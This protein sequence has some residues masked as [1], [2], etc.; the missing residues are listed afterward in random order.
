[1]LAISPKNILTF[2]GDDMCILLW[3]LKGYQNADKTS[4]AHPLIN[5]GVCVTALLSL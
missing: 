4:C 3:T 2:Y 5:F 1:M